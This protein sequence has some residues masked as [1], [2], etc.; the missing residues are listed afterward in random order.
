[1]PYSTFQNLR[2]VSVSPPLTASKIPH[3]TDSLK[4]G[5]SGRIVP[6]LKFNIIEAQES[7]SE[8]LGRKTEEKI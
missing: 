5:V 7:L 2:H 6:H 1:M 4:T 3:S 8:S